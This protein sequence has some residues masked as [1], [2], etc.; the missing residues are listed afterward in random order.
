MTS[1][2]TPLD[3]AQGGFRESRSALGQALSLS[4]I[5]QILRSQFRII[6]VLA[7]LDIKSAYDTV[8]HSFVWETLSQCISVHLS[9]SCFDETDIVIGGIGFL[10]LILIRPLAEMASKVDIELA[11]AASTLTLAGSSCWIEMIFC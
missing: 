4:E 8:N 9:K 10:K 7:F 6:P 5:C 2:G 3:I 1:E 11:L